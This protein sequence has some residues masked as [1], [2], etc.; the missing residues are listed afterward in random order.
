VAPEQVRPDKFIL[1]FIA[2]SQYKAKITV[3]LLQSNNLCMCAKIREMQI[4]SKKVSDAL[5]FAMT[6]IQNFVGLQMS[7][8]FC[9]SGVKKRDLSAQQYGIKIYNVF[10]LLAN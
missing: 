4:S 8:K 10:G 7:A 2:S 3:C 9:S 5:F 6:P 1:V